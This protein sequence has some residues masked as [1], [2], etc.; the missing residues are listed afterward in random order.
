M[1]K[2]TA[3]RAVSSSKSKRDLAKKYIQ[4]YYN[5]LKNIKNNFHLAQE[6]LPTKSNTELK[7]S[8]FWNLKNMFYPIELHDIHNG[9]FTTNHSTI[10]KLHG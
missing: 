4:N 9:C 2:F 6:T 5:T 1:I 3:N 8:N 7:K 10:G